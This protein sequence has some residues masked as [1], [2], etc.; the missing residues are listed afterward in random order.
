MQKKRHYCQS[1]NSLL[2]FVIV[3][4]TEYHKP[5]GQKETL[6]KAQNSHG[7]FYVFKISSTT[8]KKTNPAILRQPV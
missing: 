2:K 7:Q 1:G 6:K 5:S 8:R 3:A 4:G